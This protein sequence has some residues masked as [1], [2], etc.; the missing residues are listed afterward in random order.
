MNVKYVLLVLRA[1]SQG[2]GGI[3]V[4]ASLVGPTVIG[5]KRRAAMLVGIGLFGAA[6]LYGDGII[7][8]AISVL[9]AV[10]GLNVVTPALS[11]Y[12]LPVTVAILLGLFAFQGFGTAKVGA[13]FGPIALTWFS[14]I[15]ALGLVGIVRS[16][17]VL[18]ALN[19][20][21][22]VDFMLRNGIHGFL[23]LG[24]VFLA[25]TGA[26]ALY[27]D[28][29]H[30]GA[31]PIRLAWQTVVLPALLLCYYGQG[32][33]L[34][35]SPAT[36]NPFY[37][38]APRPL[39]MPM[40]GL[41]TA[42]TIIASQA[43][44]SGV[45]SL[46]HQAVHLGYLPRLRIIHTSLTERGQIYCPT[47][48]LLLMVATIALTLGFR[49]PSR[50][51]SAYGVAVALTMVITTLLYAVAARQRLGW[52]K[53]KSLV[54]LC[55]FLV[56]DSAFLGANL[57]KIL[58]G[59]W[60]PLV[61]ALVVVTV[62]AT[63]RQGRMIVGSRR[64]AR[65]TREG[66]FLNDLREKRPFRIPG[67]AIYMAGTPTGIPPALVR[68]LRHNHVLHKQVGLLSFV[69]EGVPKVPHRDKLRIEDLGEGIHRIVIRYGFAETPDVP[70]ALEM[71]KHA[72][73]SFPL[74][75]T[76]F[77]VARETLVAKGKLG[78]P[79]WREKLFIFLSRNAMDPTTFFGIPPE[80]VIE[81]GTQME[82]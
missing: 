50:L 22:G 47:I 10:D 36:E 16:P 51:A 68:N 19:P 60:F 65:C 8:P 24:A 41:A 40:V 45:F 66:A 31:K 29:G 67:R 46:T 1:E 33:V 61:I 69:G 35:A 58:H 53:A 43:V 78:M 79:V 27:A 59:A 14:A 34:L 28:L 23:I 3:L 17:E 57:T 9:S 77:F 49:S 44:V 13:L 25:L 12:V 48:N 75:D 5:S 52:S 76:S 62:L 55:T 26:E 11:S 71:A 39:L 74:R 7:T 63:W 72:G 54:F 38:L 21:H 80:Q 18:A 42:A 32:A 56:V 15:A 2:E 20:L 4:L 82:I 30:F 73:L 64:A 37:A 6:L 81:L 70:K